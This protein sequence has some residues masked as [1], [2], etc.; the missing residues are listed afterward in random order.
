MKTGNRNSENNM[1][2]LFW[3]LFW[4]YLA[5]N[6]CI[7]PSY[8]LERSMEYSSQP[9][10]YIDHVLYNSYIGV[11]YSWLYYKIPDFT[12][13]PVFLINVGNMVLGIV[14]YK[15]KWWYYLLLAVSV[16][17]SVLLLDYYVIYNDDV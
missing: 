2:A 13:I 8:L 12:L 17:C 1:I 3:A 16:L 6:L 7:I 11:F 9:W 10:A 5:Y 14:R 15:K 4:G